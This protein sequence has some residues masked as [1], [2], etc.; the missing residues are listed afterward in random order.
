MMEQT[1][2]Q[3]KAFIRNHSEEIV[4]RKNAATAYQN[5]ATNFTDHE[6]TPT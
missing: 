4:N 3:N 5:F 6:G 2:E 1:L